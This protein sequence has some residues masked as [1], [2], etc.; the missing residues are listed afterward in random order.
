LRES[1]AFQL[2]Q[3]FRNLVSGLWILVSNFRNENPGLPIFVSGLR[4]LFFGFPFFLTGFQSLVSG[5]PF[6]VPEA[7]NQNSQAQNFVLELTFLLPI[8]TYFRFFFIGR[9]KVAT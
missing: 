1:A 3:S 6:F 8:L 4:N 9:K 7:G 5:L 2:E